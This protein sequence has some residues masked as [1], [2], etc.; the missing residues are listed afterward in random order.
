MNEK[1]RKAMFVKINNNL[2][3]KGDRDEI[4]LGVTNDGDF[5]RRTLV[6]TANTIMKRMKR[7]DFNKEHAMTKKSFIDGLGKEAIKTY[8][9]EYGDEDNKMHIGIDTRRAIGQEL[10]DYTMDHARGELFHNRTDPKKKFS[11]DSKVAY[12]KDYH[13]NKQIRADNLAKYMRNN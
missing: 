6:P 1:Q 10:V 8:E 3:N 7:G 4:V 5:Y 12:E 13:K 11:Y 9:K 2:V